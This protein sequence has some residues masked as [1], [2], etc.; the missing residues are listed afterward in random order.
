MTLPS[1]GT[2]SIADVVGEFGG[3]ASHAI[4]EYYRDGAY[5]PSKLSRQETNTTYGS[6]TSYYYQALS[7]G[8]NGFYYFEY[9]PGANRVTILWAGATIIGGSTPA[10]AGQSST[11]WITGGYQYE[12]G[13]TE[14]DTN[15]Y[16][17]R[18]RTIETTTET[19]WFD[20][21]TGVPLSGQISITDFY[22]ARNS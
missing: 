10:L 6:F 8:G 9:D 3:S 11:S 21:N 20:V 4:D 13:F 7:T 22:G 12:R 19:V 5:V 18:R 14:R 2:L 15:K 17:V 1:S 16:A